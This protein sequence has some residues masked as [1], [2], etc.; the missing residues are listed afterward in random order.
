MDTNTQKL[1]SRLIDVGV[2]VAAYFYTY[3]VKH[4]GTEHLLTLFPN[5]E[6]VH[7]EC[8]KKL[9]VDDSGKV[10]LVGDLLLSSLPLKLKIENRA[11]AKKE[12]DPSE[13][14]EFEKFW[15]IYPSSDKWGAY[16]R[17]RAIKTNKA[18]TFSK[19]RQVIK[20]GISTEQLLV[21]LEKQIQE[22]KTASMLHAR[23]ELRFLQNPA[24]WLNQGTYEAYLADDT[25]KQAE[26][27]KYGESL[28]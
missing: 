17:T 12:N 19:W 18:G 25:P 26:G 9:L 24:T 21:A 3:Y 5:L 27:P 22:M 14:E 13:E 28:L 15:S 8:L 2:S 23:N 11:A 7:E 1:F 10:T 16:P 6:E 20:R 4:G